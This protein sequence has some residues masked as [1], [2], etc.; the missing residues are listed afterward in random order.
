MKSPLRILCVIH[1][2]IISIAFNVFSQSID[3]LKMMTEEYPPFNYTEDGVIKG[4][5]VNIIEMIL[6]KYGSK[7]TRKD[8]EIL[9]WD[10]AYKRLQTEN[11][12]VLFAMSKTK[13]RLNLFKWA[14]PFCMS[15]SN[16]INFMASSWF[17]ACVVTWFCMNKLFVVIHFRS[18]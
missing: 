6:N 7:L 1:I 11:N 4:L 16:F 13:E 8:I 2:L 18:K 15:I 10:K 12:T 9:P 5:S 14:G 3:D 17:R